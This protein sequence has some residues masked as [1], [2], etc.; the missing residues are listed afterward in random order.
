MPEQDYL[1][2]EQDSGA[3]LFP[4]SGEFGSNNETGDGAASGRGRLREQ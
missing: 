1:F 2:T 3:V 4:P